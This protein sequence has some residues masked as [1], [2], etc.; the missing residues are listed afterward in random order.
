MKK[1]CA[2]LALLALLPVSA[3]A[4]NAAWKQSWEATLAAAKEEGKVTRVL[5]T[6]VR[7]WH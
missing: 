3:A 1:L 7:Y 2:L 5:R 4:Q 6:D